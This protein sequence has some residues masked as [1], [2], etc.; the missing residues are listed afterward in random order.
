M[1]EGTAGTH[2]PAWMWTELF[3]T[4]QIALD[5]KKL[6]L[7]AAGLLFMTGGTWLLSVVFFAMRSEPAPA[8]YSLEAFQK[9]NPNVDV[10]LARK[11]VA[12]DLRRAQA[13]HAFAAYLAGP[14]T[15]TRPNG[16][17]R[18]AP[19]N[20]DRGRNPFLVV[21]GLFGGQMFY[22]P[23]QFWDWALNEQLPVL[24]EPLVRFLRPV[25]A[26]LNPDA[27][28]GTR[29]YLLFV[30]AWTVAVWAFFGGAITRI[31]ALQIA[32]K[33]PPTLVEAMRFVAG[34][35]VHYFAAPV[36]PVL[37]IAG[38][39]IITVLFGLIHLIPVVG[40]LVDGILWP[41]PLLMGFAQALLLVGLVG[42]PLMFPTISAEGS[43][44]FDAL[45]RSYNY[46]YQSPWRYIGSCLIAVAYGIVV[47]FFVAFMGS[48]VVFLT[49]WSLSQTPG[50]Q[51]FANRRIDYLFAHAPTTYQWRDMLVDQ[52]AL[53][54]STPTEVRDQFF[55]EN[56]GW[57]NT[58]SARLVQMWLILFVMLVVG[59]GYS[60]FFTAG[61]VIYLLM[62][63]SVDDTEFD[64]VY[65]EEDFAD[66][67]LLPPPAPPTSAPPSGPP[68]QMVDA[69]TLRVPSAPPAGDGVTANP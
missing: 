17:F 61:T 45:S 32:G 5:P 50:T 25:L 21:A 18:R 7:A 38:I 48:L 51:Y 14:A 4:F 69:P 60:Y 68:V 62:R 44:T 27:D 10:E 55:G 37:F 26:I 24:L 41:I 42:Y 59:Y 58:I 53:R 54:T 20:D 63:Q 8:A 49:K 15:D 64:E 31:A 11:R 30:I 28:F 40:D 65:A 56:F 52:P 23:G 1:A 39:A 35:Y 66:E 9:A 46:V 13:Q 47:V 6:L 16:V 3:R 2:R 57:W 29:F 19:W 34:K 67:P 12:D 43:D 22:Q 36:V 33:D